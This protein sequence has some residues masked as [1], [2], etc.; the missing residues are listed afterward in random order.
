MLV[1]KKTRWGFGIKENKQITN[2]EYM[3]LK[4]YKVGTYLYTLRILGSITLGPLL[5]NWAMTGAGLVCNK[6]FPGLINAIGF[7][8]EFMY[9]RILTA[10]S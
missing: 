4:I 3:K 9:S 2:Y 6:V 5:V 10:L 8:V 7:L 1:K